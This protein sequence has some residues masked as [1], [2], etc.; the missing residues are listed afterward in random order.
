MTEDLP[1]VS[2]A[3]CTYNGEKYL[4]A[5]LDSI[6]GQDYPNLEIV[7]ID[8]CSKDNT[9]QI[10]KSYQDKHENIKVIL[11]EVNI[12]FNRNFEKA[13]QAC[14]GD[15]IAIADQDDIWLSK[16]LSTLM[17]NIGD[18]LLIYHDSEF[19]DESGL[20]LHLS[21]ST[22]HRFISGHCAE[23]LIYFNCISGHACL[24]RKQLI[25]ITPVFNSEF[26]YDWWLGYSAACTGKISF[27]T[28]KLVYHRK[29]EDSSTQ[30]DQSD[31]KSL[32]EKQL[33]L[34]MN[35]PLTSKKLKLFLEKI[36]EGYLDLK[37][38]SFSWRLFA[39]LLANRKTLFFIRRKTIFSQIK[40]IMRESTR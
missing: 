37:H 28:Q 11:N 35:H 8:D 36:Y 39:L 32:R 10:L 23:K 12:G 33:Q 22:Y 25:Q 17:D 34:F 20:D 2:V 26:Y 38:N 24:F 40:L 29:H 16:K 9:I 14:N 1:L 21:T 31:P 27:I 3:L 4:S 7:I 6:V 19:I 30:R 13:I 15:F 18:N 5:Q